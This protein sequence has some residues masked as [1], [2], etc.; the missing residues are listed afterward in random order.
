[1]SMKCSIIAHREKDFHKIIQLDGLEPEDFMNSLN[2]KDNIQ[3]VFKAG[4]DAGASGSFFF[5][6]KDNNFIIKTM[7]GSEKDI[8]LKMLNDSILHFKETENNSLLARIYGI[9]TIKTQS[10]TTVDFIVM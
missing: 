5:F 10:F 2:L 7:R 3:N 8:G 4:Q 6:S 9:F 1:M